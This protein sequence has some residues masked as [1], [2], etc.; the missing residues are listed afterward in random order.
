MLKE[1]F[2]LTGR[3]AVVTG[4]GRGI[5]KAIAMGLAEYGATVVLASRKIETLHAAAEEIR[6]AGGKAEAVPLHIGRP[7]EIE[8]FFKIIADKFGGTDILV[9]N[10]ATNPHFGPMHTADADVFDKTMQTN[11]RGY[12]L[13][14]KYAAQQMEL[15]KKGSIINI[16]SIGGLYAGPMLG[17]YGVSK[18]GVI[19]MSRQMAR[20]M[21]PLGIRVNAIAPG[22]IKTDF[23]KTLWENDDI[24][25]TAM[26]T[27]A[28]MFL[29]QPE[30]IAGTAL[31]LASD[32]GRFITG[33]VSIVDGGSRA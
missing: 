24:L 14:C 15:K 31:L 3:V 17:V 22:L 23:S 13:M 33:T 25:K 11:L 27:Q 5:G 16:A 10:G 32:A 30:D 4:G 1:L 18:A 21:G 12:F 2:S 7:E 20:E 8:S 29:G 9:N 28:L 6:A 19:Q 26:G